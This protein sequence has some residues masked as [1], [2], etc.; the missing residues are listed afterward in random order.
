MTRQASHEKAAHLC[1]AADALRHAIATPRTHDTREQYDAI[2]AVCR[3]ALGE[4]AAAAAVAA[5]AELPSEQA[6]TD[7]LAWIGSPVG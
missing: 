4:D 6:I 2:I 5:G 7:V 3:E 1:G